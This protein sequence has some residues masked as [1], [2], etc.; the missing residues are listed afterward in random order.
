MNI[1]STRILGVRVDR[2]DL[3]QTL[4]L[5]DDF[6]KSRKTH[7]IVV[8]NVAKI[9]KAIKDSYLRNVIETADLCG[10]D[11]V[12]LV[13]VSKLGGDPIPGRVNGTDLMEKLI[14]RAAERG[15]R[16]FFFGAKEEVVKKVVEIYKHQYPELQVAGYRNGYFKPDEERQIAE[17]IGKSKADILF[18][19]FGTPKK[20]IFISKYKNIM[21]VPVIHGVGGSFD[22][23]A[24]ETKRAPLWMQNSGLEWFYRFLQEPGRMWKRYLVTNSLFI[25]FVALELLGLKK[26][27]QIL[28]KK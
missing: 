8:V 28:V 24:G 5:I 27:G 6:I 10:A 20:E 21:N 17:E 26:F 23:I 25:I 22:V 14:D 2:I 3:H 7:Q 16:I 18:V 12:P 11:G 19:A 1:P 4:L 13:W 9:V 15:Y